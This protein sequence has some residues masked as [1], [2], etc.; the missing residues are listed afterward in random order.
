MSGKPP[1]GLPHAHRCGRT[2]RGV[3][4]RSAATLCV[5]DRTALGHAEQRKRSKPS[6]AA[7]VVP[8][9]PVL[10]R[11]VASPSVSTRAFD[12]VA[13]VGHQAA[14]LTSGGSSPTTAR[15]SRFLGVIS[16]PRPHLGL[17]L[18]IEKTGVR[19]AVFTGIRIAG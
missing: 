9:E 5:S 3:G 12:V 19:P 4:Q 6:A 2:A 17:S 10:E 15:A 1:A 18:A 11:Q 8:D 14:A 13:E 7:V 16:T